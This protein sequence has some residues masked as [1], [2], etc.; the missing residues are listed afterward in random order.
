MSIF[1]LQHSIDTLHKR[2]EQALE[3]LRDCRLCPRQCAVN[4]LEG[5]TGVCQTARQAK[6]ASYNLHFGEEDPLVG[7]QGSGTIFFAGCN[8]GCIFCQNY[9]I[10]HST[11][12]ALEV[13]A[14]QLAA[15]MLELQTKGAANI[16]L[17]TPS[18]VLPQI[19]EAL[20]WA[21][22]GGLQ[23]PLVYNTGGYDLLESLQL[24]EGL[25]Q[26][27]MPDLKFADPEPARK[28][29]HAED[30]PQTAARAVLEMHRQVGDLQLDEQGLARQGLMIRHLLLPRNLAGTEKWLEFLVREVSAQTYLNLMDQYRPCG[31]SEEFPEL[32]AMISAKDLAAAREKALQ[33]GL[34]RLDNRERHG[35]QAFLRR[36]HQDW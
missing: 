1:Y 5:Q 21:V 25:I 31:R 4:R 36:L 13:D 11:Q 35:L 24:A 9:D 18:H 30:Y 22:Q 2:A 32:Q 27:Y 20:P 15:L 28:Y 19:L 6:I 14:R 12:G 33:H 16:N 17:V 23:L 8:L 10:S 7:Q 34:H 26:I 3:I 29:C